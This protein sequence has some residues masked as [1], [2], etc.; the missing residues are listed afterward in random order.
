MTSKFDRP[1]PSTDRDYT[2]GL[3]DLAQAL[4]EHIAHESIPT[5]FWCGEP[6]AR[7]GSDYCSA[8]CANY[9]LTD[10]CER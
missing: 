3:T 9:A 10:D 2:D 6:M 4:F 1:D 5:C 7:D 8:L